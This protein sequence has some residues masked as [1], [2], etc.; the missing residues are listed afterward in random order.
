VTTPLPD[1]LV[2]GDGETAAI[3]GPDGRLTLLA[4][5]RDRFA[6]KEWLAVD[7]DARTVKD[8]SLH[9]GVRC[10]AIGCVGRLR[11]GRPVSFALSAEAFAEDCARAARAP[12]PPRSSTAPSGAS[13]AP[14]P[15]DGSAT[16]F[17]KPP[18]IRPDSIGLGATGRPA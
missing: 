7:G 17:N 9:E 5:G 1:I 6:L 13:R 8:A 18:P 3:R 14:S 4:S 12:A 2:A 11:D 10:D 16:A 15:C